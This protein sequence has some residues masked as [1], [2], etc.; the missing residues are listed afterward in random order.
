MT[1]DPPHP[2]IFI[3]AGSP[4]RA[5]SEG[6]LFYGRRAHPT[7]GTLARIPRTNVTL[8]AALEPL[9][10]HIPLIPQSSQQTNDPGFTRLGGITAL[11]ALNAH[12]P[13]R[14]NGDSRR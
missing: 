9:I 2:G 4:I 13:Q 10:P 12:P 11:I 1:L 7:V 3:F 8:P 6:V 5:Q 14:K